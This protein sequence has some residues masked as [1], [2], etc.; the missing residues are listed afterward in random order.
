MQALCIERIRVL[1][2]LKKN[3]ENEFTAIKLYSID[4]DQNSIKRDAT[5]DCVLQ[6]MELQFNGYP[7]EF[8]IHGPYGIKK[9]SSVKIESF[10]KKL[11]QKGH[12]KYYALDGLSH[13]EFGFHISYANKFKDHTYSELI[14]WWRSDKYK[15]DQ[16]SIINKLS[17]PFCV[18]S[19]YEIELLI[20]AKT[21]RQEFLYN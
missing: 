20:W 13:D 15:V 19:G 14:I 11:S 9:G 4:S 16:V 12:E 21:S 8:D 1:F 3:T 6:I 10:K 2:K 7:D 5:I 17:R 18:S